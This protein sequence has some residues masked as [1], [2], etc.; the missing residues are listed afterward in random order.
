MFPE[1][2]SDIWEGGE[3][4]MKKG[5][6][7]RKEGHVLTWVEGRWGEGQL[8]DTTGVEPG[9]V[10]RGQALGDQCGGVVLIRGA[11]GAACEGV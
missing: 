7:P 10:D 2:L 5:D 9:Q 8:S 3:G 4:G 11:I 1:N 6:V